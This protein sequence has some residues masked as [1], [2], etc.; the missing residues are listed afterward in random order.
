MGRIG[1]SQREVE[2]H[3]AEESA[4]DRVESLPEDLAHTAVYDE[5]ERTGET[6]ESV[7]DENDVIS[8]VIV[9]QSHHHPTAGESV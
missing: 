1:R 9:Q 3:Q 2:I 6:H 4:D 7:D 8:N 5:V